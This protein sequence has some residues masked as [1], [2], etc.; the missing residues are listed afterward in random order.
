MLKIST[1]E[2]RS[3]LEDTPVYNLGEE[4]IAGMLNYE[5][6][7]RGREDFNIS[8]QNLV[9]NKSTDSIA[10]SFADFKKFRRQAKGI[11]ELKQQW[12]RRMEDL[13]KEGLSTQ[14][15]ASLTEES[16]KLRDLEFLKIQTPPGP[17]TSA[18]EL[19]NYMNLDGIADEEKNERLYIEVRYAKSSTSNMK[20]SSPVFRLKK[21]YKKLE[22]EDYAHNL[23]LYF[24]CINSISTITV[25]D[26][27][28]IL[29]GLNA[30]SSN[31]VQTELASVYPPAE[32]AEQLQALQPSADLQPG[33]S[34][35][36]QTGAHI[37]GMWSD[38]ADPTGL[39]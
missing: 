10:D 12:K 23:R 18:E 14:E 25:A 7:L 26:F 19:D 1:L 33:K 16:K 8:S 30:A 2:D 20:R 21:N 27:S 5:L 36:L 6:N 35:E 37:A 11:K 38:E 13:E 24:G 17:F 31:L 3:I 29:T 9:V 34:R 15:A 32:P 28:Y 4:R 39:T 22:N